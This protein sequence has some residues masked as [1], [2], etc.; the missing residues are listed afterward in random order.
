MNRKDNGIKI[1]VVLLASA[2]A[3]L[4]VSSLLAMVC[5]GLIASE[6]LQENAGGWVAMLALFLGSFVGASIAIGKL[7]KLRFAMSMATAA[8]YFLSLFCISAVL[9]DGVKSGVWPSLLL[10]LTGGITAFLISMARPGTA[11]YR[12]PKQRF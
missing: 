1:L 12:L 3:G 10:I 4:L 8:V 2:G 5:A 9:F 7:K 11:K 6:K